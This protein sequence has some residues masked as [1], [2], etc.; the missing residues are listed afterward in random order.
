MRER[1]EHRAG[2][3]LVFACFTKNEIRGRNYRTAS[4]GSNQLGRAMTFSLWIFASRETLVNR[5]RRL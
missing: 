3:E 1:L 4:E 2:I 5:D